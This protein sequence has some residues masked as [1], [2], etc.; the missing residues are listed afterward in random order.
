MC[1][2]LFSNIARL[3]D[4]T[5]NKVLGNMIHRGP[6]NLSSEQYNE[7]FLGHVRLS[8]IDLDNR[9]NQPF[10]A[11]DGE[12]VLI[13]NGQIY[14]YLELASKFDLK[15]RTKSDTEVLVELYLKLGSE[16]L[17]HLN[18][19]FSFVIFNT[20]TKEYFIARDRLGIKPLYYF[21]NGNE[22]VFSS[23]ISPILDLIEDHSIDEIGFRQYI[24][25]RTFFR[26]HTI[27]KNIKTFPA[28]HFMQK[29]KLYSYWSLDKNATNQSFN[30]EEFRNLLESAVKYRLRSDVSVGSYL[31][32]GLDSSIIASLAK[33][34]HTWTI[35]FAQDN[36][37]SYSDILAK[38]YNFN[39]HKILIE[40][41]EFLEI[42]QKLISQR[43]EPLSVP[44]EILIYKMTKCAKEYNT[45]ILSGEGADELFLGYDRIFSWAKNNEFDITNFDRL[46]TYGNHKDDEILE[47]V[48]EPVSHISDNL[49]KVTHFFQIHHLHG[50]LRR[51]DSSTMYNSVEARVPFCDHRLV[52]YM[53][54]VPFNV[55]MQGDVIKFPL[56]NLFKDLLPSEIIDRK[57][58]GFPVPLNQ[59]FYV[60]NGMDH[61]LGFNMEKLFGRNI[62]D[63]RKEFLKI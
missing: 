43:R 61:W 24:K 12:T 59:I 55:K 39:H 52:E 30:D 48:L 47:Y 56:K 4:L 38:K 31:S 14:N 57:K 36:E 21:D 25:L 16:F 17:K 2:I 63:M 9:S 1:G 41:D 62:N 46:Y 22:F 3:D 10:L 58:V 34:Q 54:K 45:V 29:G 44:N 5:F 13:F 23:E 37:F 20:R 32:G 35:G 26:G 6:D 42:T 11:S 51:L 50:L 49:L 53:Y 18:G 15:L 33:P 28:G 19:M 27:Y 60:E 8:I 40:N 7:F